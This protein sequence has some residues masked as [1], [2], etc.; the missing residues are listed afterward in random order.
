M[1][2]VHETQT[3]RLFLELFCLDIIGVV[4]TLFLKCFL[5]NNIESLVKTEN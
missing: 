2:I 1:E 4:Q 5:R 3:R